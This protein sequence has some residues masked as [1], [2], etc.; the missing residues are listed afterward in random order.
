MG[1]GPLCQGFSGFSKMTSSLPLL[2]DTNPVP[3]SPEHARDHELAQDA[4]GGNRE[5]R[6][7]FAR[8]ILVVGRILTVRNRHWGSP[9]SEEEISDLAQE[10]ILKIWNKLASFEGRSTLETWAYK[11]CYLELMNAI[12]K[13]ARSTHKQVAFDS[14]EVQQSAVSAPLPAAGLGS[15]LKHLSE[16]ESQVVRLRHEE[17]L[18]LAEAAEQL[19]ISVSSTKTHYYRALDKLRE[20][21]APPIQGSEAP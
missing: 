13:Q 20:H 8:R 1:L 6:K 19:K 2:P 5:A 12:R 3:R 11:Y 15:Y 9:L 10:T 16:R 17:S 7:E 18:T 14:E 21:L 4:L